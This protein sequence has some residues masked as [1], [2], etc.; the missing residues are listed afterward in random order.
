MVP[1]TS[2]NKLLFGFSQELTLFVPVSLILSDPPI[3][4][5]KYLMFHVEVNVGTHFLPPSGQETYKRDVESDRMMASQDYSSSHGC[6]VHVQTYQV[7]C[8]GMAI[9]IFK[10]Y[11]QMHER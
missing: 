5:A 4:S 3:T 2:F 11:F 9:E 6:V 7:C 1:W 10:K 8:D